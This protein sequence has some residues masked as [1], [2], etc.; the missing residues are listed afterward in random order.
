MS[1]DHR[2]LAAAGPQRTCLP[3]TKREPEL[4]KAA[5]YGRGQLYVSMGKKAQGRNLERVYAD[6][7]KYADVAALLAE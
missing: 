5:R 2:V 3:S 4:L 7:P 6:D 1:H